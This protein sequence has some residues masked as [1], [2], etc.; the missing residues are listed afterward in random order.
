MIVVCWVVCVVCYMLR[1]DSRAY[2]VFVPGCV[3]GVCVLCAVLLC[4]YTVW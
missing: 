3:E 2:C 1:V 4:F